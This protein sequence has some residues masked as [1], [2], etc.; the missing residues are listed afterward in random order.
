MR[1]GQLAPPLCTPPQCH[2]AHRHARAPTPPHRTAPLH[3]QVYS[4][5]HPHC[6]EWD[7]TKTSV[8]LTYEDD[9]QNYPYGLFYPGGGGRLFACQVGIGASGCV[10]VCCVGVCGVVLWKGCPARWARARACGPGVWEQGEGPFREPGVRMGGT[11]R[12]EKGTPAPVTGAGPEG[13]RQGR[14]SLPS[15]HPA[16]CGC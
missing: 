7:A 12:G 6:T 4:G 5:T 9:I 3:P 13:T 10:L 14:R 11:V 15:M 8:C 1:V 16:G 2:Q